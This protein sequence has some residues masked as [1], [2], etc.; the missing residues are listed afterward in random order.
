MNWNEDDRYY[1]DQEAA[2]DEFI[3]QISLEAINE[4]TNERLQSFY[5]QNPDVMRPAVDTLQEGKVLYEK[6]HYSA[7]IVFFMS[8]IELLLKATLLKPLVYGLMHNEALAD[9]VVE[10]TLAQTG[11]DRYEKLIENL[12]SIYAKKNPNEICR[13]NSSTKL[14]KECEQLQRIRNHI[15]HKGKCYD[16]NE[17]KK[18][19]DVSVAVYEEIVRPVLH[20]L[21]L[22]IIDQGKI[23]IDN[24]YSNHF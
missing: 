8:A 15:I 10:H 12:I 18:A 1:Y 21:G 17:A 2:K 11:F 24:G 4:F 9:I 22:K 7:A 16:E 13:F 6:G 19:Q 23:K 20:A 5:V 14:L 3:E